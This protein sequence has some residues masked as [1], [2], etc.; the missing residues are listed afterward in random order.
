[1]TTITPVAD[2]IGHLT[3]PHSKGGGRAIWQ[4][5]AACGPLIGGA[6]GTIKAITGFSPLEEWVLKP[7]AGDWDALDRAGEAW[8]NAGKAVEALS[9][10]MRSVPGQMGD[11]WEGEGAEA[12]AKALKELAKYFDTMPEGFEAM[13]EL[14]DALAELARAILEMI[15]EI[16]KWIAETVARIILEQCFPIIGQI[17]GGGEMIIL[18]GRV[19]IQGRRVAIQITFFI[20]ITKRT[21]TIAKEIIKILEILLPVLEKLAAAEA[22]SRR[23]RGA[24]DNLE[25]HNEIPSGAT[26]RD[27]VGAGT[28]APGGGGGS[29]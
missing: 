3:A 6:D 24:F 18:A 17:I 7:F 16:L 21:I 2:P 1:M 22:A 10:N 19:V 14:S 27:R 5:R 25:P 29:W 12:W 13:G 9:V 8:R 28:G 20:T 15:V 11:A 26:S 23:A 4:I